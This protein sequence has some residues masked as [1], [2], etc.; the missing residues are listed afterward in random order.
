MFLL[1]AVLDRRKQVE[2]DRHLAVVARNGGLVPYP[3]VAVAEFAEIKLADEPE[4]FNRAI[5][6]FLQKLHLWGE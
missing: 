4:Q 6:T 2:F 1:A 5:R 3:R